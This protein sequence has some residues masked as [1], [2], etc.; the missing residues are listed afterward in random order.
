MQRKFCLNCLVFLAA[1]LAGC[2]SAG[3]GTG[4]QGPSPEDLAKLQVGKTTSDEV[5]AL[6]GPPLRVS[7]FDRMDRDVW[8]YRRYENPTDDRQVAVQFS[9][10]GIVREVIVLKDYN[11]EPCGL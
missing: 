1:L 4:G 9:S 2:A 11:R 8:E 3:V 7:R 10:D 5:R 6:L